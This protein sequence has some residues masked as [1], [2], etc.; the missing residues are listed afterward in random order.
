LLIPSLCLALASVP[1][2]AQVVRQLIDA[3]GD[4]AGHTLQGPRGIALD[5]QGNLFVVGMMSD[6]VFRIRPSG[7][8]ELVI[9]GSGDGKGHKL[10]RPNGIAVDAKGNVYV[11]G[12]DSW[13]VFQIA[14]DGKKTQIIDLTGDARATRAAAV[15]LARWPGQPLHRGLE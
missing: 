9:D 14:P 6:N 11:A 1:A 5:A 8:V 7:K 12:I 10:V 2:S 15:G 4:G 13:N 3:T